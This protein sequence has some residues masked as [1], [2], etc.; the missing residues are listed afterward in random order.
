MIQETYATEV[1][2]LEIVK[3]CEKGNVMCSD[4]FKFDYYLF[5][6][7]YHTDFITKKMAL[8]TTAVKESIFSY[9]HLDTAEYLDTMSW[10]N[11]FVELMTILVY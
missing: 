2:A 5:K 10:F 3:W 8:K 9:V 6:F 11:T 1:L 7:Y 4:F